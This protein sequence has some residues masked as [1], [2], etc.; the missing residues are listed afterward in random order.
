MR[1]YL[2]TGTDAAPQFSGYTYL[3][4]AGADFDA[5]YTSKPCVTDWNNDGLPDILCGEDSGT[6]LLLLN[7]GTAAAPAFGR[8]TPLQVGGA[9][10]NLGSRASPAVTDWNLDGKKDVIIGNTSGNLYY[11]ENTGTDAAPAFSGSTQLDA[12]GTPI[13]IPYYSRPDIA[14]W[15][16]DGLPDILCGRSDGTVTFF[17]RDA[18]E[19]V[20]IVRANG[21][22]GATSVSQTAPLSVTLRLNTGPDEGQQAD[23]WVAVVTPLAQPWYSFSAATMAWQPGL[24]ATHQGPLFGFG[25]LGVLDA[26]GL[27]A[28]T[29]TFYFAVDMVPNG[30]VD[31]DSLH[32]SHVTV[33][34]VAP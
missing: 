28:G 12:G 26:T 23:W 16:N 7:T 9:A 10:L 15:D 14:D 34:I 18:L 20:P 30:A 8:P 27:P 24:S 31:F 19:P 33:T 32:M 29:Y 1:I 6:V 2:N 25:P 22:T 11:L 21:A 3:T 17:H 4:A 5:G 13:A